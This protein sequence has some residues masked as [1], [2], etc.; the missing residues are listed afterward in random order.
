[1][2]NEASTESLTLL[3][4]PH[5]TT[6]GLQGSSPLQPLGVHSRDRPGDMLSRQACSVLEHLEV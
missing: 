2:L 4:V 6:L 3:T 1:M 5:H